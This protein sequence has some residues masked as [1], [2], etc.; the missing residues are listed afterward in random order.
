MLELAQ[1]QHGFLGVESVSMPITEAEHEKDA[2]SPTT[3]HAVT[4]SYWRSKEDVKN[5]KLQAEHVE[6]QRNGKAK[7]Y[8]QYRVRVCEVQREYGFETL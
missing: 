5:W 2:Q 8:Q 4:I 3:V 7:W 1:Q 6:A